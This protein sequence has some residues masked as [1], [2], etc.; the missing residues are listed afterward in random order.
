MKCAQFMKEVEIIITLQIHYTKT[1]MTIFKK[2]YKN[3]K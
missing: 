1:R 2:D 3:I